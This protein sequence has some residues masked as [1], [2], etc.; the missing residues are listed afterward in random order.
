MINWNREPVATRHQFNPAFIAELVRHTC[1]GHGKAAGAM[2]FALAFLAV[3]LVMYPD[4]RGTINGASDTQL[5]TWIT[6]HPAARI[7]LA[8][9][10]RA[11]V[12]Y[13]RLGVAFGLTQRALSL[14]ERGQLIVVRRVKTRGAPTPAIE[15][16]D[17][18]KGART[19]GRWFGRVG[20]PSNVFLMLG[21]TP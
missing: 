13:V 9:R 7:S 3:P 19:L 20:E 8:P 21:L 12:P 16:S 15:A 6:K 14:D 18:M 10:V 11:L 2:P 5:H 4:S 1:V 17:Y